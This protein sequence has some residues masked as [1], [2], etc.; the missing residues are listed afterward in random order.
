MQKTEA[1]M[2]LAGVTP[3]EQRQASAPTNLHVITGTVT[4]KSNSG[5]TQVSVDGLIFTADNSQH[6]EIDTLGGLEEGDVATILLTGENGHGMTPL[7]V[8]APGS[9]DRI[10]VRIKSI[11]ADYIKATV[12]DAEVARLG[13][14]TANSATIQELEVG[15]EFVDD[16]TANNIDVN[17]LVA[18]SAF[19]EDLELD[20]ITADKI[21]AASGYIE[22][23]TTKNITTTNIQA[24]S[25]YIGS[26]AAQNISATD[27][28]ADH[29]TIGRFS[30]TY[31][32]ITNLDAATG[33]ITNLEAA[34]VNITG[35][36]DAAEAV[37]NNLD[38]NYIHT[39]MLNADVAW[40]QNGVIKDGAIVNGMIQSVSANKLTAGTIDASNI[41]VTNL[42]A[43][44]ITTGT[45]NGQRI[46]TGSLSLDKLE[47]DVY[48]E[49]EVDSIVAGL[50]TQ[51]DGAIETW[52]GTEVPT[53]NN[54]P[55]SSWTTNALK[56][57]HVGDIYYVLN[58]SNDYDGYTYRFAYDN[59]S[60][61]YKWVLIKDNQV[62]AALGRIDDLEAFESQTSTWI[63]NT[64]E[65]LR[66]I[67][68]NHTALSGRVDKVVKSSIQLWFTKANTTAPDA[69]TSVVTSNS[70][71]GNGWRTIV[72]TYNSS[73]PYY[74]YCWQ[75]QYEDGT[76]DWS[77]VV[78]DR[79]TSESEERARTGVANAATADGKAV[80]AQNT[81]NANIKSSVQ[82]WFTKANSTAPSKPSGN[83]PITT[84]DAST[85]NA[86]NL[87][88]PT[89][90]LSYPY[91]FYCYQQQKGDGTYQWTDV[92]YDEATSTAMKKAQEALP[93]S[94]FTTFEQ[95]TF[96]E[97]SDEV[98]E[99][100]TK[101]TTLTTITEN[102]GLTANT[103]ISN[104]V[105][106]VSQT[107]SGNS[108]KLT[109]LT[110]TIGA[111]ADGTNP[112]THSVLYRTSA[113]E[114]DLDGFKSTVTNN[115]ATNTSLNAE[116]ALRKGTYATCPTAADAA[117]KVATITPAVTGYTL[118]A[119][120]TVTVRFQYGNTAANLTLN[121]NST[122]A[123]EVVVNGTADP[124]AK[125]VKWGAYATCTFVYD[126]TYWRFAGS[127]QEVVRVSTA[128]TAIEQNAES[129]KISAKKAETIDGNMLYDVDTDSLTKVH[130]PANRYFSDSGNSSFMVCDIRAIADAPAAGIEYMAHWSVSGSTA[131]K[132]RGLCFYSGNYIQF[133]AGQQYTL[134]CWVRCTSGKF[135]FLHNAYN[136]AF[137]ASSGAR[138][139][140]SAEDSGWQFV[141]TTVTATRT[142]LDRVYFMARTLEDSLAFEC[143]M[144]GF[145]MTVAAYATQAELKVAS[146]AI[147]LK[148]SKNDV[149]NQINVSTEGITID[150]DR[151]NITGAAIFTSG[152]L[153]E[154]SLNSTY[155]ANG[156]AATV[157]NNLDNL[158]IGGRNL[159]L[160]SEEE[161]TVSIT[162]AT[163]T[164]FY[165]DYVNESDYG[166]SLTNGNTTD[167]FLMSFDWSTTSDDGVAWIQIDGNIVTNVVD[168]NGGTSDGARGKNY[169]DLS[170]G[171]GRYWVSF[172]YTSTQAGKDQQR[173]RIRISGAE[174]STKPLTAGT[175]FT[176]SH[177]KL[178][179][180]TKPTDWSP[181]PEDQ[182]LYVD[183]SIA[184]IS[185]GGRNL[186][187]ASR[188]TSSTG[189]PSTSN[190]L[191]FEWNRD[192]Y[193]YHVYGTNSKTDAA[194]GK[195]ND[196][197]APAINYLKCESGDVLTLSVDGDDISSQ[198]LYVA[199][200]AYVNGSTSQ[201]GAIYT[202]S[203]KSYITV[204][205]PDKHDSSK[206]FATAFI[207]VF[208]TAREVDATFKIKLERGNKATDWSPA[209][210]DQES[211]L[212]SARTWYAECPTAAATAAKVATITP[213]TTAFKLEKGVS[214]SV[215]FTYA[216]T[217]ASPTLNVNETGPIAIM[218][219][220]STA[221]S[222][223]AATSWQANS[224]NTL[225]YD[226]TNWRLNNWLND[227][228]T[229]NLGR[230]L[231]ATAIKVL[232][233]VA[234]GLLMVGTASGYK[235]IA[236]G[237]TF[238]LGYPIL[239]SSA[240]YTA[241][242]TYTNT[243]ETWNSV[244]YSSTAAIQSG[245][246]NKTIYLKGS[247]SGNTFTIAS[248]NVFTTVVPT[249]EDNSFYIPLG[250][251]SSATVGN[252]AT[253]STLY[254]YVDGKF[255]QATPTEI[256]ATHRVYYRTATADSSLDAPTSW[257]AEATGNVYDTWT[258]KVPPLAASTSEGQ[259]KYFYLYTCEQRKR[260]DGT[261]ECTKVLL[262]ENTTVIDGGTIVT[263]TITANQIA[264]STI[265]GEEIAANTI[266][267]NNIKG[268]SITAEHLSAAFSLD[269]GRVEG[270]N[271]RLD[272]IEGGISGLQDNTQWV[273]YDETAGT[274][275]G[276]SG[277]ANNV[278]VTGSGI[279]FNT[280]EGRA[281]WAT[282]GVFHAN[283]MEADIVDTRTVVMGDWTLVHDGT[284]F[285]IDYI[286]S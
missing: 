9:I 184:G 58:A 245:A 41:T 254:A 44:N 98:D 55:A 24:A 105:N 222:T 239:Y 147:D 283:E 68:S 56:S 145:K 103:N 165:T 127:D 233:A 13:Y 2:I 206:P 220:G 53:L 75:Y 247:I 76:Y 205:L 282:G 159:L 119:G 87:V 143:D 140:D 150:A 177:F 74:F 99:Q 69:P 122:G 4:G 113:L 85:R 196:Y 111:N 213:T 179:K 286:G 158:Q 256:V 1:A 199:I 16:L 64:D 117:A 40:L 3:E 146:D 203:T 17:R 7:A 108:T 133:V 90:S 131:N 65:G 185:I 193:E 280:D 178:E 276:E 104:T 37:V 240:A 77:A 129:I 234:S 45:I 141:T 10:D 42:N 237:I 152:R 67:R 148:V 15:K 134:S 271:E 262:D 161:R 191:T 29:G 32:T 51:I 180:G 268:N 219:Y 155:D 39:D 257:V 114:Q 186:W 249:S 209:P 258:T 229:Y 235:K 46:G 79:A 19:I 82:L 78:Y 160:S 243:Y 215:K 194:W 144:C 72:P 275:F 48:T 138:T 195:F 153:S 80:A 52:T 281:A 86:W 192:T 139:I 14:L 168:G 242:T 230:N 71:N 8:G 132:Q 142:Q 18:N 22:D 170:E 211:A 33:R 5:K 274:I 109:N 224:I 210:E 201:Y 84:S 273:H 135:L 260:L 172:R 225:T 121:V 223:S 217:V 124:L 253:S 95:S 267:G 110:T 272:S 12:L 60:N 26:L 154:S 251:M 61:S 252:F 216:N 116:I 285:Y 221:P 265:T 157:Q 198:G 47:E 137:P 255:R 34:D 57:G 156:A 207:G 277:S 149:I 54:Y 266:D 182:A 167:I 83:N 93:S 163:G 208:P 164:G 97:V 248:S 214:V 218:R 181:A 27:I 89:Y 30:S 125:H 246:A 81:A 23:L 166:K 187:I 66:T 228:T 269:L 241:N 189:N 227:N 59:T 36:L 130:G 171:S 123:K 226:G 284:T 100:S 63:T 200:N 232:E 28:A 169:L 212:N 238:S 250:V 92:V 175:T 112:S 88:V 259:T 21:T 50:Q 173:I 62:T 94:T 264:A 118:Y 38:S 151:V 261:I 136:N 70:T 244:T 202:T 162:S 183:N 35:R 107:A 126:G 101:I 115:Y 6:I 188:I 279:D 11:E 128:E 278:T 102:N 174:I 263:N 120:A 236:A 270:L 43:D 106:E 204:T 20:G 190:G 31:A 231:H 73:Y 49:T 25:G 91:Y 197:L 96:K 176:A